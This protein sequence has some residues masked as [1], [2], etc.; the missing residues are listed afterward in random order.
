MTTFMDL[1]LK[2]CGR[3]LQRESPSHLFGSKKYIIK[4]GRKKMIKN[5]A[6]IITFQKLREEKIEKG[7]NERESGCV[8]GW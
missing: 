8:E 1:S 2:K 3:L 6:N 5:I 7:K 4:K